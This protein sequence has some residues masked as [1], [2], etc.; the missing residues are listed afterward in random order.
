MSSELNAGDV[1]KAISWYSKNKQ[2]IW[3][4]VAGIVGLFGGNVDRLER[5]LPVV[6]SAVVQR[7][8][9]LEANQCKC[10][11]GLDRQY[12]NPGQDN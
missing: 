10:Q 5:F 12:G 9:V 7:V 11:E 1:V 8:E 6:N 4:A 2:Y 3:A